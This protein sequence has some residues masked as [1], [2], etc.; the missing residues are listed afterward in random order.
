MTVHSAF[1]GSVWRLY[2]PAASFFPATMTSSEKV[3]RVASLA[4]VLQ[5]ASNGTSSPQMT[6]PFT[7]GRL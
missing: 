4:P 3:M 2:V 7:L 1:P 6:R 5:T